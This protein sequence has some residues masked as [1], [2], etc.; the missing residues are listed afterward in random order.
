MT[1]RQ[2]RLH[3]AGLAT[4]AAAPRKSW[5][6]RF[7]PLTTIQSGWIKSLIS[8][9]GDC[10]GGKTRDQY[11]LENIGKFCAGVKATD[12]NDDQLLRI[13]E[14]LNQARNEGF[15]GAAAFGRAKAILWP[16]TL[17]EMIERSS[18]DDD[19]DFIEQVVLNTF[20]SD[21]PVYLVGMKFYTSRDKISDITREVQVLA[22][23]LSDNE[24]RKRVRWCLEIFRAKVYLAVKRKIQGEN[25]D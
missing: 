9:W 6:G 21:D 3:A 10:V 12:W 25:P 22:P 13:T 2:R 20:K 14:A 16:V 4:I 17:R 1:P 8:T 18:L 5:L 19:A 11:R 24:A 23:W 7:T 15:K